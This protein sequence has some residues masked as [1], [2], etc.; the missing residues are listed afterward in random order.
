MEKNGFFFFFLFLS[1][2]IR[3]YRDVRGVL[4]CLSFLLSK[5]TLLTTSNERYKKKEK[6]KRKA[7]N[8]DERGEIA[9]VRVYRYERMILHNVFID[10]KNRNITCCIISVYNKFILVA[11]GEIHGVLAAAWLFVDKP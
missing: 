6:M 7:C 3:S 2:Y 8:E 11:Y 4:L 5:D 10:W 1:Y 9:I